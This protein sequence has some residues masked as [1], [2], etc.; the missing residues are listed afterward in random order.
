MRSAR[1]GVAVAVLLLAACSSGR[2]PSASTPPTTGA[3]ASSTVT[4]SSTTTSKTAST[5]TSTPR[6]T[7]TTTRPTTA[8]RTTPP[9]TTSHTSPSRTTPPSTGLP[10]ALRDGVVTRLPTSSKV[11]ALTFDG[12][13]GS[14]GAAAIL[15]TLHAQ[16]VPASFFV[17]GRFATTNPSTTRQ[18][19]A[20]GPVGNHTWSHPD[21]T[22]VGAA[23]LQQE[24]STTRTA[25]MAATGKDPRPLFRF[26]FGAYDS[27]VLG[28]VHVQGYG[29]V[30]WT[31]DSLGWKGTSGGMTVD[32]VV[33][34]V[35]AGRSP[36][37]VVL[38]HVGANPDDG[39]TLDA[40]ALPRIIAGYRAAGY[41][42]TTLSVLTH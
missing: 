8:P 21:L 38:M 19:A 2:D 37:Q 36:G 17:T 31:T 35:L 42:F 22:T 23:T 4:A 27:R 34:R 13:A 9:R 12:G 10:P 16:G 26:P 41:G 29:A 7:T 33:A 40:A 28:L 15:A 6:R 5:T 14:Q 30:G 32:S 39:T 24:L 18:M 11:V 20:V 3:S 1:V 25:I